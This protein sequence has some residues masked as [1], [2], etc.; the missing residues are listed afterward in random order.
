[1]S[2]PSKHFNLDGDG[3]AKISFVNNSGLKAAQF[4]L[5]SN[6]LSVTLTT[7]PAP[8]KLVQLEGDF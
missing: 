1:M 6:N 7:C 2:K 3:F 5:D 8:R 4:T